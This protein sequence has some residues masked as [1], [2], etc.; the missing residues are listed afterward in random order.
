MGPILFTIF[1]NDLPDCVSSCCK[2]FAD[3]TKIYNDVCK[4][5]DLQA[6]INKLLDWTS[7]WNLF[8]NDSKCKVMHI[9][10]KNPE[11]TYTM[12][13]SDGQTEI[14]TC[15]EEKDLGVIFDNVLSFESHIQ[16]AITKANQI[17]GIIRRSFDY[18]SAEVVVQ[19]YKSLVRPHLEYGNVIWSPLLKRQSAAIEKVQRRATKLV[20]DVKDLPY[21]Q[22]LIALSLPSLKYRRFRGD[23][24]QYF[25]IRS[26]IDDLNF[27]TFFSYNKSFCTRSANINLHTKYSRT[28]LRKFT[29]TNRVIQYW[30]ALSTNTKS[31]QQLNNFKALLDSDMKKLVFQYDYDN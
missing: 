16:S 9:G 24:I 13:S 11:I 22:R 17:L 15:Y 12:I 19:L 23:L 26:G 21:E 8:F 28:N 18:L 20:R 2:I 25:K 10:K 3:D 27:D 1:I 30:N 4:S 14:S 6:D 7:K 5:A 31:A 29:F